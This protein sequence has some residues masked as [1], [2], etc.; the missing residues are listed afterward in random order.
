MKT[1]ELPMPPVKPRPQTPHATPT[2]EE[3][4]LS[5]KVVVQNGSVVDCIQVVC[6][7]VCVCVWGVCVWVG[8]CG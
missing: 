5:Y 8:V 1:L 7:C 2:K 4:P 3:P 6:V